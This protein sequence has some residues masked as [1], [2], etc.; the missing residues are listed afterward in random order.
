MRNAALTASPRRLGASGVEVSP[1]G[2]GCMGMS[3]FYGRSDRDEAVRTLRR[4]VE[5]GVT[6][7][8][9]AD[10]YGLGENERL[11]ADALG[12]D[13]ARVVIATKFGIVRDDRGAFRGVDGSASYARR[14][15]E[16]SLRRLAVESIDLFQLHRV[17][18]AVPL[19][20]TVGAMYELVREGKVRLLGLSEVTVDQ[21]R[22]ARATA[23]I[24]TVQSEYSVLERAV[25]TA[26]LRECA[27]S[28]VAFLAFAPLMRGLLAR[29][30]VSP[31]DL[32]PTDGRRQGNY[33]RLTGEPLEA[34]LRLARLVWEIA[35]SRGVSPAQVALAWTL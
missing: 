20:E 10:M 5:L 22:L 7:F 6:L 31:G 29:R 28:G 8:D 12:D 23:P 25:E 11:L 16:A 18:P 3:D 35:D 26:I 17:D 33:P 24:A 2:L 32:D 15:C 14:A 34:N 4:A 1:I 27:D 9:T 21:L 13:R 30:F 19:D